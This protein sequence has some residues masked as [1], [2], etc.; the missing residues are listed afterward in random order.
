[1]SC[2]LAIVFQ[3]ENSF[4]QS[5]VI[6]LKRF[7]GNLEGD[8]IVGKHHKSAVVTL[9]EKQSKAIITLQTNGRKASD[10]EQSLNRWLSRFPKNLFKSITFDMVFDNLKIS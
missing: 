10:I 5:K 2:W 1:M 7:L 4:P 6:D 3:L 8:T 9:V